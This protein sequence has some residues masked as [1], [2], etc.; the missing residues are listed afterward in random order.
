MGCDA[1]IRPY[2]RIRVRPERQRVNDR[3]EYVLRKPLPQRYWQYADKRPALYVAI[4][5]L[6]HVLAITRV[7]KVVLPVGV[8]TGQVLSEQCVVF[9]TD[10]TADLALLSSAPH[11]WWTI[12]HASTIGAATRYTPSDVFETLP[13]PEPTG[14]MRAAGEALDRDRCAFMLGRQLG[15]TKT[16]NLVHDP[17][18]VD[19]EVAHLR[20]LHVAVD[21]AVCAAYSWDDLR[22]DHCHYQTRQGTRWTV[23]LAVQVELLDR[24]LELNFARHAA[25]QATGR[26]GTAGGRRADS[27]GPTGQDGQGSLFDNRE[28]R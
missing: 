19:A 17:A 25:E 18:V 23:A 22:L 10:D 14:Q 4:E 8:P 2:S 6:S 13:Q 27:V 9:A 11:Y 15:L 26:R 28:D 21:E 16:Y 24:L 20:A 12:A 1:K 5:G 3:G 7:S